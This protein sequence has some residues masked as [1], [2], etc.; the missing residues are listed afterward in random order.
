MSYRV[1]PTQK[2]KPG[3]TYPPVNLHHEG[4]NDSLIKNNSF[5]IGI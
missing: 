1:V 2:E 5:M 4:K 3:D